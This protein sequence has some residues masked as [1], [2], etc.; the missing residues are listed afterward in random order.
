MAIPSEPFSTRF[1]ARPRI[2]QPEPN[3]VPDS[4]RVKLVPLI[5]ELRAG[6]LPGATSLGL[7]L[8]EAVGRFP[9]RPDGDMG[10]IRWLFREVEWW[11]VYDLCETLV[12]L[13]H[14]AEVVAERIEALFA[15]ENLP[16][17]MTQNG[18]EWRSSKPAHAAIK[19]AENALLA[20]EELR[21]PA[22]QW[23]KAL[24]H[25]AERPPDSENCIKDAIAALEGAARILSGREGE[26]LSK[27]IA[28]FAKEIEMH[29][30]LAAIAEK[31]YAYRGD[32]QGAAHGATRESQNLT[33]EAELTL[34]VSAALIVYL[35][36]RKTR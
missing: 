28:P 27:L 14:K 4:I 15:Q 17:A 34:H 20:D 9:P 5:N 30:A 23:Q 36:K 33:A 2:P 35:A 31:L 1:G 24:S 6:A 22:G 32:E 13:A 11:E 18:I 21:G 8:C 3:T 10:M 7:A 29:P 26:T 16:Y 19:E 25:L 12:R